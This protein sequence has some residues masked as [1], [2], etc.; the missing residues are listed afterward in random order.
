MLTYTQETP[1]WLDVERIF[2]S[3]IKIPVY[4]YEA[5]LHTTEE[6]RDID[7]LIS[8]ET[9]RDY[10]KNVGD[11]I[12]IKFELQFGDY[13]RKF[14]PERNNLEFTLKR[15]PL[16][17]GNKGEDN[18]DEIVVERFKAVF[19]QSRNMNINLNLAETVDDFTL[20]NRPPVTV[21]LQLI[22][23]TLEPLRIKTFHGTYRKLKREDILRGILGGETSRIIV[24]GKPG[25]DA[26]DVI[27]PDNED[28]IEQIVFPDHTN[29]INL[30]TFIQ[31]RHNGIYSAGLGNYFQTYEK[32][33]TWF[34]YPLYNP[35][36][37]DEPVKKM[38]I[39]AINDR[40]FNG[41]DRTYLIEGDIL[42]V[43]AVTDHHYTDDGELIQMDE[44]IGFRQIMADEIMG[45]P[46]DIQTDGP[47][48]A[49][50]RVMNETINKKR[51]DG[52][53]YAPVSTR[54][55]ANNLFAEHSKIAERE[56]ALANVV[57]HN[58]D[59]S[60]LYPGMPC[61]YIYATKDKIKEVRGVLLFNHSMTTKGSAQKGPHR[62]DMIFTSNT[63]M[64]LF[65]ERYTESKK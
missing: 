4:N 9:Q 56:G 23:R 7:H 47:Y 44:G 25:I 22:N 54:N 36:R 2:D 35:K 31:E 26:F 57:W 40:Q 34:I 62:T 19:D 10:V 46:V 64:S 41:I 14:Y 1:L 43:V 45:K 32:K 39:Y 20:N 13:I 42:S 24:D 3:E 59:P 53:N 12:I 17:D 30:P 50:K 15:I 6:D 29:V 58:S 28:I 16:K 5:V 65:V 38:I 55:I 37:F 21:E 60:L 49:Q 48:G 61:K 8:I 51:E 63:A 52:L 11:G 33:R 18:K 27:P